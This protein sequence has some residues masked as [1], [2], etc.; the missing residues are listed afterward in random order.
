MKNCAARQMMGAVAVSALIYYGMTSL[1]QDT[2][3]PGAATPEAQLPWSSGAIAIASGVAPAPLPLGE[4]ERW[5]EEP[6]LQARPPPLAAPLPC[7]DSNVEQC[8]RWKD[9]GDCIANSVYM[10]ANCRLSCGVCAGPAAVAAPSVVAAAA[11]QPKAAAAQ[12]LPPPPPPP[13]T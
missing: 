9:L 6:Q 10:L 12:S 5:G 3:P 1:Q 8:P 13:P 4:R 11:S 7:V 2:Q